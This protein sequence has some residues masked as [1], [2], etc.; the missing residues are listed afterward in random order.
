MGLKNGWIYPKPSYI[1]KWRKWRCCMADQSLQ[2]K[3]SVCSWKPEWDWGNQAAGIGLWC[4]YK[5]KLEKII[6]S[7]NANDVLVL[8]PSLYKKEKKKPLSLVVQDVGLGQ[9]ILKTYRL[10]KRRHKIENCNWQKRHLLFSLHQRLHLGKGQ[11][12]KMWLS[13]SSQVQLF[14]F[15]FPLNDH[16]A[17][18]RCRSCYNSC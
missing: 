16:W 5:V 6:L 1:G 10:Q 12:C 13:V 2:H 4:G 9:Q 3:A 15:C 7:R 17:L 14:L 11:L 18:L 8:S